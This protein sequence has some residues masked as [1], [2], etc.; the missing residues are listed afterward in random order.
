M[1]IKSHESIV[2]PSS[3]IGGGDII[4]SVTVGQEGA[5]HRKTA[6]QSSMPSLVSFHTME[7][8]NMLAPTGRVKGTPT[9]ETSS[10]TTSKENMVYTTNVYT[11]SETATSSIKSTV[12]SNFSTISSTKAMS[13][14]EATTLE[15]KTP[16]STAYSTPLPE[17][18]RFESVTSE[19]TTK[20]SITTQF[21]ATSPEATTPESIISE[22]ASSPMSQC[23]L[24]HQQ[25]AQ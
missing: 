14:S 7:T 25:R 15:T 10:T 9:I 4:H 22:A 3:S 16:Q 11:K 17:T 24:R 6:S 5:E 8:T 1:T 20:H 12:P 13:T 19:T 23:L 21:L 18:T 2:S